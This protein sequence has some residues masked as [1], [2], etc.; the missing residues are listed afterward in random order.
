VL[1]KLE[2]EWRESGKLDQF[3]ILK[4]T[5]T[6]DRASYSDLSARLEMSEGAV[7]VTVHRLR[8]RYRDL[9]R[10]EI[11]QTV[12]FPADADDELRQLF[13]ALGD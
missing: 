8:G 1:S 3:Q 11:S 2:D 5:I 7:R 4:G 12:A 6:G 10:L 13:A 9:L